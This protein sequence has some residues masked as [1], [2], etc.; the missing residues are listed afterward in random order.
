M[1]ENVTYLYQNDFIVTLWCLN[2][3]KYSYNIH[4]M[5]YNV[6]LEL[7]SESIVTLRCLN[8]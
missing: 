7:R 4:I 8:L 2:R 1:T 5:T 6:T 3:L